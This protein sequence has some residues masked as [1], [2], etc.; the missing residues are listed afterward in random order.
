GGQLVYYVFDLLA[1]DGY[2]LR[3]VALEQRKEALKR[4]LDGEGGGRIRFADHVVGQG[5]KVF[6]NA[7]RMGM[8]GIVSKRRDM[9]Y[10]PGRT[11]GWLKVKCHLEQEVVVG[12]FSD[13][14]GTRTGLGALL[15]G[16]HDASGRLV[17][18]GKVGTGFTEKTLNELRRTLEAREQK[19]SP[20]TAG[21][22]LPRKAHWV[23]P[24]L[25]AVVAFTEWTTD[26]HLRHPTFHGLREDKPASQVTREEPEPTGDAEDEAP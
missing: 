22:G 19:T 8:E 16:V 21:S 10:T 23:K 20:F 5:D 12:G 14:E 13:P 1:L 3:Q 7:C 24:D 15:V 9:P 6:E 18:A 4:L 2:D 25:V 26:G 17:Y 11:R